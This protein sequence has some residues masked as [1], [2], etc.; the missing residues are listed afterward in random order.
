MAPTRC[1]VPF[2]ADPCQPVGPLPGQKIYLVCGR[3]VL[4]PGAYASWPSADAQYKS[5]SN[6]TVKAYRTW[7]PLEAVWFA[8]CDR[9]EH[10]HGALPG[11][12]LS[13]TIGPI[14]GA[15]TLQST[16]PAVLPSPPRSPTSTE[17]SLRPLSP[18]VLAPAQRPAMPPAAPPIPETFSSSA[19]LSS[20]PTAGPSTAKAIPGK[21][22]YAVKHNDQ[23]VVFTDYGRAQEMYHSLQ[24]AGEAPS[25]AS[26][27]S[28]T[29][30]VSFVE[31]FAT[32]GSS[33]EA[34]ARRKWI[35]EERSARDQLVEERWTEALD[36]WRMNRHGVWT[37]GSD[38]SNS[39]DS[40]SSLSTEQED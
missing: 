37:S 6:A 7:A 22:V 9:G 21:M 18:R 24:A 12:D 40:E 31:G 26:C 10:H 8:A 39:D 25:L 33:V 14:M 5:V 27:P 16:A 34:V 1:P 11:P 3:N 17:P 19:C 29:E 38:E 32:A 13:Q 23:G 4:F 36:N 30:G 35:T 2:Y 28:L 20:S 15:L